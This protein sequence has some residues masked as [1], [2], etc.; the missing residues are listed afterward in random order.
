MVWSYGKRGRKRGSRHSILCVFS[1]HIKVPVSIITWKPICK[2]LSGGV[3]LSGTVASLLGAIFIAVIFIAGYFLVYG[4]NE[5]L[6]LMFILCTIGGFTGSAIDSVLGAAVQVK[7]YC[8]ESGCITE[9]RVNNGIINKVI[10]GF[11]VINNDAVNFASSFIASL[12]TISAF[13]LLS[14]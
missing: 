7:Y 14:R 3:T 2:G 1:P 13:V 4:K 5:Y 6:F 12:L 11:A 8:K 10:S 9:K